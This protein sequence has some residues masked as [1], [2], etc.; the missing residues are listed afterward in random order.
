MNIL[1]LSDIHFGRNDPA[2]GLRDPFAK[3]DQIL[4]ELIAR[5]ENRSATAS[6]N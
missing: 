3:H 6:R 1:H 5:K 2:Y 4:D